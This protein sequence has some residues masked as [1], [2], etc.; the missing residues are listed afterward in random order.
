MKKI[1]KI[2]T[3]FAC[4]IS[5]TSAHGI[6]DNPFAISSLVTVTPTIYISHISKS[7]TP[8]ENKQDKTIQFIEN[9]FETLQIE[10]AKG[11]GESLDTLATFYNVNDVTAWKSYLQ[12]HYQQVF[13]L[14]EPRNAF[15]VYVYLEDITRRNFE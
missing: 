15:S 14:N 1:F 8:K 3:I 5:L 7:K 4:T 10:I 11:E 13:F 9:N 12:K 6:P 2:I